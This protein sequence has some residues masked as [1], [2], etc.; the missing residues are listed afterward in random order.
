MWH[1]VTL[2]YW[3]ACAREDR[4]RRKLWVPS[5]IW[6]CANCERV[7]RDLDTFVIHSPA[8]AG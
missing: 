2:A 5:G 3:L 1:R 6:F 7:V 8:H 4:R